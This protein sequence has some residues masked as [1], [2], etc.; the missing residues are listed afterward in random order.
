LASRNLR[1][2]SHSEVDCFRQCP[3]KWHL[4]YRERWSPPEISPALSRGSLFHAILADHYGAIRG[5]WPAKRLRAALA[6]HLYDELGHQ[7]E[8][9]QLVEWMYDGYVKRWADEDGRWTI[10]AIE[11][12]INHVL[13]QVPLLG[14]IA[15]FKLVGVL[16]LVVAEPDGH[17]WVVDHKTHKDLPDQRKLEYNDQ[18]GLYLWL[19]R[20]MG[21]PVVGAIYNAARTLRYKD[22]SKQALEDRFSR[23]YLHRTDKELEEVAR[24]VAVTMARAVPISKRA[25]AER[26]TGD[27]CLFRC[28]YPEPCLAGRKGGE[29]VETQFLVNLGFTQRKD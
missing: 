24:E 20:R 28:D 19:L 14:S 17:L 12:R 10:K 27:H 16:D 21:K 23:V 22:E 8:E 2:V 3:H 6:T 18:M 29:K 13:P 4:Q 5:N 25:E 1:S 15:G 11:Q 26:N 9:Q 7:T